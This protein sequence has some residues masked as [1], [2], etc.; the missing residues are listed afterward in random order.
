MW[1]GKCRTAIKRKIPRIAAEIGMWV[2]KSVLQNVMRRL[3]EIPTPRV[4]VNLSSKF[5]ERT[6]QTS[7]PSSEKTPKDENP[8]VGISRHKGET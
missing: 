4:L 6:G 1:H 5:K 8:G 7:Y 2:A 3:P